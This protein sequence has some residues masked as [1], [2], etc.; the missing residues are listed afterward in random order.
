M[1][2]TQF[3]WQAVIFFILFSLTHTAPTGL[4]PLDFRRHLVTPFQPP[5][6]PAAIGLMTFSPALLSPANPYSICFLAAF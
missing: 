3:V 6:G 2:V 4:D 1:T 5:S